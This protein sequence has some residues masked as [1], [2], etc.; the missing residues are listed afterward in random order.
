MP[1]QEISTGISQVYKA[2]YGRGPTRVTTMLG[3]DV[4]ACVLED[5]NTTGQALL[6]QAGQAKLAAETHIRLQEVMAAQMVEVV[7]RV[8]GRE[9]RCYVPGVN[10]VGNAATD[11]FLLE[12]AEE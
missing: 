5:V 10:A 8:L 12:P 7:E 3:R 4:V 1:S 2:T 6:V 9:V 11:T